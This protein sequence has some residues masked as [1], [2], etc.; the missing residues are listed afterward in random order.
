MNSSLDTKTEKLVNDL[1]K[2]EFREWTVLVVTHRVKTVAE[3]DSGFDQVVVL[4][5]GRVVEK[6]SPEGLLKKRGS[7]FSE[8]VQ[9]QEQ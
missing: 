9:M 7:L 3:K 4:Q 1:I 8:M 2:T 5:Q 6:G